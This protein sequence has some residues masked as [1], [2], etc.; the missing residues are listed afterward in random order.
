M[1]VQ[2]T[3]IRGAFSIDLEPHADARG[4]FARTYCEESFRRHG[5]AFHVVQA[6]ISHN[7]HRATLRGM[8]YRAAK[9][10]PKLVRC[11]A[12][13]IFDVVVD[14]RP[15]SPSYCDWFGREL[16]DERCNALFVPAGCAHGFLTLTDNCRVDYLMG[17]AYEPGLARGARW[18]D[19]AFGIAWPAEPAAISEQDRNWPDFLP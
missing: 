3:S 10:E 17:A 8:H 15:G 2:E 11:A 6:N 13:R 12:G 19:P 4:F 16:D 14:L 9:P 7:S 5:I 18:N 1:I